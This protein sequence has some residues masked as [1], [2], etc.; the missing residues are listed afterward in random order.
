M[1]EKVR[2]DMYVI[3]KGWVYIYAYSYA[4]AEAIVREME[5]NAVC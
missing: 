2:Y 3:G 1:D 5:K 4:E